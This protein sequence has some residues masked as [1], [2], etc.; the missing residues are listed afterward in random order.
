MSSELRNEA[1][2]PQHIFDVL[3]QEYRFTVDACASEHNAKLPA[4]LTQEDD[5]LSTSWEV[6]RVWCNPPFNDIYAWLEHHH[7]PAFVAYLLPVRSDRLW[8]KFR[9]PWGECHYFVGE[10]PHQRI[11]FVAPPGVKYSS[12]PGSNCLFLFG[13]GCTP[14]LEVWRSGRT[15]ERL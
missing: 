15:G 9:K 11:Q 1:G 10:K 8:W 12:N 13:E 5:A 2:T 4:Y 6:E 7:E 3:H 14:G